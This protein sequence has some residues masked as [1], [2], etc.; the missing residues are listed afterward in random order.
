MPQRVAAWRGQSCPGRADGGL[1]IVRHRSKRARHRRWPVLCGATWCLRR[2]AS[3]R[4]APWGATGLVGCAGPARAPPPGALGRPPAAAPGV[5]G[6]VLGRVPAWPRGAAQRR[7]HRSTGP[8]G[9]PVPQRRAGCH[10]HCPPPAPALWSP[11]P[12]RGS[13]VCPDGGDQRPRWSARAARSSWRSTSTHVRGSGPRWSS[14]PRW[15]RL[16]ITKATDH[17]T[18][19]VPNL[20]RKPAI[21]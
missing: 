7:R 20:A 13:W 1:G 10:G 19:M 6:G 3:S 2:S 12:D 9:A 11:V 16:T 18:A 8:G 5:R 15:V 14:A 17:S 4:D 21:S